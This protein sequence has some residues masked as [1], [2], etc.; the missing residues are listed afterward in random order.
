MLRSALP[1]QLSQPPAGDALPVVFD[2]VD[3]L[4]ANVWQLKQALSVKVLWLA[5]AGLGPPAL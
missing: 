4:V 5:G 2:D 1:W 3:G